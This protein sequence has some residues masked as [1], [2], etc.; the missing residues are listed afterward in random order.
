MCR[1][2]DG[3]IVVLEPHYSRVNHHAPDGKLVKQ[4]G[5]HGT[6]DGQ[7]AFPR[8]VALDRAGNIFVSEYG[9]RER[10]QL[11][12]PSNATFLQT[13]GHDGTANGEFNRPEGLDVDGQGRLFVADSCNHRIQVF[14]A[15]GKWLASYGTAGRGKGQMSYPYDVRVDNAGLQFVC[16]FGN[17]R[18]QVFSLDGKFLK[19]AFVTRNAKSSSTTGGLSFSH[20]PVQTFLYVADQGNSKV[21]ILLRETLE[22]VGSFGQEGKEPG[23]FIAPHQIA[24]DVKGN[25]YTVEVKGGE[26]AQRFLFK[27]YK[28]RT[29]PATR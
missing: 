16:E 3:N 27:G 24:T 2:G 4:W 5:T 25:V 14:S 6:N 18:I 7:L 8:S 21:H 1:D 10:V 26:R 22:E 17:S 11:F 12:A 29:V 15:D 23:S 9:L 13:I 28:P 20:D 19:Q